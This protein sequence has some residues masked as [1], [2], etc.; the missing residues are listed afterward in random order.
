MSEAGHRILSARANKLRHRPDRRLTRAHR[1]DSFEDLHEANG[2][3]LQHPTDRY[4]SDE[5][6]EREAREERADQ[7]RMAKLKASLQPHVQSLSSTAHLS[8]AQL[9]VR[10]E[11]RLHQ[12]AQEVREVEGR[13]KRMESKLRQMNQWRMK[14]IR[15]KQFNPYVRAHTRHSTSSSNGGDGPRGGDNG[16][17]AVLRKA[18]EQIVPMFTWCCFLVLLSVLCPLSSL[19]AALRI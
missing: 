1:A 12:A 3:V 14:V 16:K 11:A 13:M 8:A 18:A 19:P 7:E 9:K 2:A 10:Y 17:A 5:E 6:D 15:Q 4:S